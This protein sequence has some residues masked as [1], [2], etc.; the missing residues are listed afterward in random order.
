[1]STAEASW[2]VLGLYWCDAVRR[3]SL[4]LV[5]PVGGRSV[6]DS[7]GQWLVSH[8]P[9]PESAEIAWLLSDIELKIQFHASPKTRITLR[10]LIDY[11]SLRG[12]SANAEQP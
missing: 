7:P 8:T 1:M 11:F 9:T 10:C 12:A 6:L 4:C 3:V 2:S 5:E